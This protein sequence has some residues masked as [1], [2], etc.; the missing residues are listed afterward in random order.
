V[1]LV[2]SAQFQPSYASV[3]AWSVVVHSS[4]Y[5]LFKPWEHEVKL[6]ATE[7]LDWEVADYRSTILTYY[8]LLYDAVLHNKMDK[9]SRYL[10]VLLALLLKS[11]G[12]TS[13]SGQRLAPLFD[14]LDWGTIRILDL[15]PEEIIDQ[16]LLYKP[17]DAEDFA[18]AY[19]S[20]TLS[21]L[22]KLPVNS[23]IRVLNTPGLREMYLAGFAAVLAAS[24]YFV[25]KKSRL[26]SEKPELEAPP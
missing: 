6:A 18:R 12:Y 13:A 9:A 11:K 17:R 8:R 19:A 23:F 15:N 22:E 1:V 14:T 26:E 16:W 5:S 2:L 20:V 25:Y 4:V 7:A 3:I 21:L 10:G 24:T